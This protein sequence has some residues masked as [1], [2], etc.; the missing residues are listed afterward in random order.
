ME[1]N[2]EMLL[3]SFREETEECLAQMEQVL[4]ALETSPDD[5]ELLSSLFRA[6]HTIK[7]KGVHFTEGKHEW[8]SK[9]ATKDELR[10][11]AKELNIEE[12]LA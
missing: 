11:I 2:R 9:I 5:P 4:L 3:Q 1:I 7:G 8:H 6:A 12:A 10:I